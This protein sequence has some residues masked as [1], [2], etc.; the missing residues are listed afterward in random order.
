MF[1]VTSSYFSSSYGYCILYLLSLCVNRFLF[2]AFIPA[3]LLPIVP[4]YSESHNDAVSFKHGTGPP[5]SL[6]P[7]F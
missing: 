5:P 6:I 2:L 1:F 4:R 7:P 3:F